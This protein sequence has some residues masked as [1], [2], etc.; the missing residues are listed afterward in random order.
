MSRGSYNGG[1]TVF[2]YADLGWFGAGSEEVPRSERVKRIEEELLRQ[3]Q[4]ALP[5]CA[6]HR[7]REL[8]EML[9]VGFVRKEIAE[10]LADQPCR[11]P[12]RKPLTQRAEQRI[13]DLRR[14]LTAYAKQ[15]RSAA[16]MHETLRREL[17]KLLAEYQLSESQYPE[18][19]KLMQ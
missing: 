16:D 15:A 10:Q 19:R 18:T 8:H 12:K 11:P 4:L 2:T 13:A 17:L 14:D 6:K 7:Q 1:G 5:E 3:S 9:Q